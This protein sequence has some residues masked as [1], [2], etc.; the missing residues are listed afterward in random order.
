MLK[1]GL[2]VGN[3]LRKQDPT[4]LPLP[5]D[6]P[7]AMLI[8]LNVVHGRIRKVPC[9]VDFSTLTELAILID[10]YELFE[11]TEMVAD[12]WLEDLKDN[13]KVEFNEDLLRWMC[14]SSV[15]KKLEMFRLVIRVTQQESEGPIQ[16]ELLPIA[17]TV[18]SK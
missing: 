9:K 10:R 11:V 8:L 15:F 18:L 5:E 17:E 7:A 13:I 1:P 2:R 14:I 3:E 12:S 4:E 16:E 6:D